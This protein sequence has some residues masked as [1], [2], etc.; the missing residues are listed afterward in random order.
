MKT[1]TNKSISIAVVL[2]LSLSAILA[3]SSTNTAKAN[4][5]PYKGE[6]YPTW[7]YIS[8]APTTEGVRPDSNHT[9]LV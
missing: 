6:V 5:T 4:I 3:I 7:T 8:V 2:L 9:L 1:L